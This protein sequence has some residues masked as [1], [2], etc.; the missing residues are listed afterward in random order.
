MSSGYN[1]LEQQKASYL[2]SKQHSYLEKFAKRMRS[3]PRRRSVWKL[4]IARVAR[5]DGS[6]RQWVGNHFRIVG[7]IRHGA[8]PMVAAI[9]FIADC[10]CEEYLHGKD[11][12]HGA[13]KEG[14][15]PIPRALAVLF[16]R[17][18]AAARTEHGGARLQDGIGDDQ[19]HDRG[20]EEGHVALACRERED[21]QTMLDQGRK[22]V[23]GMW[24]EMHAS[25]WSSY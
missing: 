2:V 15:V 10:R 20:V 6:P 14:E 13:D 25:G 16:R 22:E 3:E 21:R 12:D 11:C 24:D 23:A 9:V 4:P 19:R 18:P 7:L 5:L 1:K 17:D 8:A